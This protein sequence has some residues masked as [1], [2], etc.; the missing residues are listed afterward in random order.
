MPLDARASL[1]RHHV[2]F[3]TL[4]TLRFDVA[5]AAMAA[6]RTPNLAR[7]GAWEKRHSPASFT[8]A[9][10]M[11]FFAGFLPTPARPGG[12]RAPRPFATAFPGSR[13]TG[14]DTLVFEEASIVEG[15]ARAGY[16]TICIGGT[17]F[18]DKTSALGQTLPAQFQDSHWAPELGVRNLRSTEE[19]VA[20]AIRL[21]DDLPPDQLVFLFINV[22]ACHSPT[23]GYLPDAPREGPDTQA[24]ALAYSDGA[25]GPL[26]DRICRDR[27]ALVV[28]CSDHGEAFGEDGYRGH[29]LGHPT[30]WDVPYL[31]TTLQAWP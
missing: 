31:E 26:F 21:L 17:G 19:Q 6:G 12:A 18:F 11:A 25:L 9:A 23:L 14:P 20:L 10:H 8:Y 30:V 16:R 3:L 27:P 13:T 7:L 15:Y 5:Q 22:T 1:G 29:R 24:A 4:D 28:V 2:L